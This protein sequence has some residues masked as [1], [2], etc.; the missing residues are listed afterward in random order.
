MAKL[1]LSLLFVVCFAAPVFADYNYSRLGGLDQDFVSGLGVFDSDIAVTE[2]VVAVEGWWPALVADLDGDGSNELIINDDE[3]VRLY[4]PADMSVI[5]SY[6]SNNLTYAGGTNR[7]MFQVFDID[8]D[9]TDEIIFYGYRNY[10]V[11]ILEF[12]GTN[13]FLKYSFEDN[14][15]C[16]EPDAASMIPVVVCGGGYCLVMGSG[17]AG[18][19]DS[20][21]DN[22]NV[23]LFDETGILSHNVTW[24]DTNNLVCSPVVPSGYYGDL[25]KDGVS[26]YVFS[27]WLNDAGTGRMHLDVYE[28][29]GGYISKRNRKTTTDVYNFGA[30]TNSVCFAEATGNNINAFRGVTPPLVF[31]FDGSPSNGDEVLI[32]VQKDAD[33]FRVYEFNGQTLVEQATYPKVLGV[34][35]DADGIIMSNLVRADAFN[36]ENNDLDDACILGFEE[37]DQNIRLMCFTRQNYGILSGSSQ[38]FEYDNSG[39]WNISNSYALKLEHLIHAGQHTEDHD[40]ATD[41]S[42]IISAKGVFKINYRVLG[43]EIE[44]IYENPHSHSNVI[45]VDAQKEGWSD[46][47]SRTGTAMYYLDDGQTNEPAE[48]SDIYTNPSID[49]SIKVNTTFEMRCTVTDPEGDGVR[50]MANIYSGSIYQINSSWA[51]YSSSPTS[52]TFLFTPNQTGTYNIRW[53]YQ[54]NDNLEINYLERSFTVG[55]V[56]AVYGESSYSEDIVSDD[57]DEDA[58]PPSE[59]TD[60][61]K[62]DIRDIIL[63]EGFIPENY[64]SI[65]AVI[66]IIFITVAV[67][68]V[69]SQ[70]GVAGPALLYVPLFVGVAAWLFFVFI[71]MIPGWTVI[72][73]VLLGAAVIGWKFTNISNSV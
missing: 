65:V 39:Q 55:V 56:G 40:E 9:G 47:L 5:D 49:N 42:E 43:D 71:Q 34:A 45:P 29:V 17:T 50:A 64:S 52:F 14:N 44:L 22:V 18:I 54:D 35:A 58:A 20:G 27:Y 61:E 33:E 73:A 63:G 36:D 10:K 68:L 41:F 3:T 24:T 57:E 7:Q 28:V 60:E 12:N 67:T 15:F 1:W 53:Y 16:F 11:D 62:E 26:E 32:G 38:E 23:C 69:L 59:L 4:D 37:N 19:Y 31:D 6:T 51:A 48:I 2:R 21:T 70:N 66:A 25:D 46:L 30:A 72:I 8:G 13:F